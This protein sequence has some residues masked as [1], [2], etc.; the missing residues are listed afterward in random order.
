MVRNQRFFDPHLATR[1]EVENIQEEAVMA[2]S[3]QEQDDA[4]ADK[5]V[6]AYFPQATN[7][8]ASRALRNITFS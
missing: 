2:A 7:V 5:G 1:G 4:F 6:K 3:Q 8:V